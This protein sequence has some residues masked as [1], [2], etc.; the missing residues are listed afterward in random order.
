MPIPLPLGS[1]GA[2]NREID[3]HVENDYDAAEKYLEFACEPR[4]ID[5]G[6]QIALDEAAGVFSG[7][8]RATK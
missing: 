6:Q 8:A 2:P 7:A 5:H 4:R 1:E 3:G